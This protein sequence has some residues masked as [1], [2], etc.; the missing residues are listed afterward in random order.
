MSLQSKVILG[1]CVILAL[2]IAEYA[3][4]AQKVQSERQWA[5]TRRESEL[6]ANVADRAVSI[7]MENGNGE[8]TQKLLERMGGTV[9]AQIRILDPDG[10]VRRSSVPSEVGSLLPEWV[11]NGP[12]N[13][14]EPMMDR[15]RRAVS[16][17][18]VIRNQ[19]RCV[20]C[21]S[22]EGETLGLLNVRLPVT[23]LE[24]HD[25][26]ARWLVVSGMVGLAAAGVLI[27]LLFRMVAGRRIDALG[28]SMRHVESGDLAA[29]VADDSADELGRLGRG[30]N[31]MVLRL[32]EMQRQRDDEHA[33][34]IRRAEQVASLEKM[35]AVGRLSSGIA[36][37]INNPLNNISLSVEAL[38]ED[39]K[40]LNDDEK[41]RLLQDISFETERASEI[42]HTLLDF[43][44]KDHP[45]MA[46]LDV[47]ELVQA[48][49]R[50]VVSEMSH[51]KV[52]LVSQVPAGLPPVLGSPN[53]LRQAF[54]NLFINAIQAMPSGGTLTVRAR[55][56]S[57]G[58]IEIE[59]QDEGEGI[60]AEHLAEV[61]DP[62]F[63]TKEPGE[64]TG[65]GL[66]V[67]YGI[68]EKH[69]GE[70]RVTSVP[71]KG[72]TFRVVLPG[73]QT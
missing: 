61:F 57:E 56:L 65:L 4:I 5:T 36:H 62:F 70:I 69:G 24:T 52:E 35:A 10:R 15:E 32:A 66:W 39:F 19:P 26:P 53:P 17:F 38:V 64:G 2:I 7:A 43:S 9:T 31:T 42:V 12:G 59:V 34:Q 63:T 49:S 60:A 30:F 47:Q 68:I 54:L 25:S 40:K 20:R 28:R 8:E 45:D 44:R 37:E 50:L 67:T 11:Q 23:A 58:E 6:I 13:S 73:A 21:H 41:W 14:A 1:I 51:N 27:A 3:L 71:G 46:P 33:E 55:A 16:R 22:S 72:T 48:T 18:L 29:R